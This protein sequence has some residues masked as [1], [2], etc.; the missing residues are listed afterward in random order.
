MKRLALIGRA[1]LEKVFENVIHVHV[2]APAAGADS[3]L[4]STSFI[5]IFFVYLSFDAGY[6]RLNDIL[7]V[8][9]IQICVQI[10]PCHK[11]SPGS[12][13]I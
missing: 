6:F 1:A 11:I 4:E 13:F 8:F 10:S 9:A 2:H 3:P 7:T 12:S 5:N